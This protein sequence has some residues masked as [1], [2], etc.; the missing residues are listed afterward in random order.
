MYNR[1]KKHRWVMYYN[2]LAY[3]VTELRMTRPP[4]VAGVLEAAA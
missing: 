4:H 2:F 3:V 1:A